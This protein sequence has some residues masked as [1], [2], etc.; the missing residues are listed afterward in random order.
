MLKCYVGYYA[1]QSMLNIS[2]PKC[3]EEWRCQSKSLQICL[4]MFIV[5]YCII[6]W[7]ECDDIEEGRFRNWR[8]YV[9]EDEHG[10]SIRNV[11]NMSEDDFWFS[12]VF[13]LYI[14]EKELIKIN[15]FFGFNNPYL[16]K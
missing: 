12:K 9:M 13:R 6:Y 3:Q 8:G 10:F 11:Y 4:Q 5:I 2:I 7:V 16:G 15:K 14:T 1:Y